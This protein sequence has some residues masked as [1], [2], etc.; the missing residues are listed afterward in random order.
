[1][2]PMLRRTYDNQACSVARTLELVGERWTL[3][4]VRDALI[5]VSRFGEFRRRLGI[6]P[7]VLVTR[8]DRLVTAGVLERRP[9]QSRPERYA[10]QLTPMGR[11]LAPVVLALKQWGQQHLDCGRT[12][13]RIAHQ[14]PCGGQV[15]VQLACRACQTNVAP[16]EVVAQV[17]WPHPASGPEPSG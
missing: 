5:G 15:E 14:E 1:M 4:I 9:Y 8:L 12:Q 2:G 11:E 16:G 13:P 7:S 6:T 10:Y 3:L 17:G